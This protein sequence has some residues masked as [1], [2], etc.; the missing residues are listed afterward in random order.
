MDMQALPWSQLWSLSDLKLEAETEQSRFYT[1]QSR[2]HGNVLLKILTA[3]GL[4]HEAGGFELLSK[5]PAEDVVKIYAYDRTSAIMEMLEGPRL[6]DI[7]DNGRAAAA[8]DIQLDLT[9]RLLAARVVMNG[10]K[11]LDEVMQESISM[12]AKDIPVW[13]IDVVPAAQEV[14][15]RLLEKKG[16]WV[17]LHGDLHPRNIM[18]HKGSWRAI[19]ARGILGPPAFEYANAF[20]NPWDRKELIFE[21]GRM[22]KLVHDVGQRLSVGI[23]VVAACAIA[24]ALFYAQLSFKAGQG[25]HPIKC[26]RNLMKLLL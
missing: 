20:I 13:A 4:C 23:D 12:H 14:S 26:I 3:D 1:C 24:N 9:D 6:L 18:M 10:L 2:Q 15:R 22:E 8:L 17:T 16:G 7:I 19:D 11:S 5:Y 21:H 25:R